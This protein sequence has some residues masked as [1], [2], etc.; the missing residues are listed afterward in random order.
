[1]PDE[2]FAAELARALEGEHTNVGEVD[3]LAR[4]LREASDAARFAIP[5]EQTERALARLSRPAPR[6]RRRWPLVAIAVAAP[7]LLVLALLL[8]RGGN[9]SGIE[10]VPEARAAIAGQGPVLR[11]TTRVRRPGHGVQVVRTQWT[12]DDSRTRVRTSVDGAVV[13]DILRE[14]GG[15]VIEYRAGAHRVVVVPSCQ[16]LPGACSELVDPIAFYRDRIA[17]TQ[18]SRIE[19]VRLGGRPAYRLTLPAQSLGAGTTRIVQVVTL[20]AGSLLPR[21]IVWR[22]RSGG[23]STV[24]A[25]IDVVSIVPVQQDVPQ[26]FHVAAPRGTPVVELDAS[27]SRPIG[28]P[29]VRSLTLAQ[30]RAEFPQG[31]WVGRRFHGVRL[32]GIHALHWPSGDA[33]RLDYGRLRIWSLER[34]IPPSLADSRALPA[35]LLVNSG[36]IER[37]YVAAD[38]RLVAERDLDGGSVAAVAP[39]LDKLDLFDALTHVRGISGGP[40]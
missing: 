3:E 40:P 26:T 11:V 33:L 38:G 22:E 31:V 8:S 15:R 27:G 35:K 39:Q 23:R 7:A 5:A 37:F 30:A 12:G 17:H 14:P 13:E 29:V 28:R 20:D 32:T 2:A 36:V 16:S 19:T 25:V 1:V 18:P 34:V 24:T 21:R 4:L 6:R 9:G 10:V